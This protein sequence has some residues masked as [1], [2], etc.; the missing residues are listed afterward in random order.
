MEV[1]GGGGAIAPQHVRIIPQSAPFFGHAN[2][3]YLKAFF[4]MFA[5]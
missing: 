3:G 2:A 5:R 4:I 1:P